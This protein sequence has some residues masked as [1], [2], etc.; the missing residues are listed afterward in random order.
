MLNTDVEK[1]PQQD[2]HMVLNAMLLSPS[3]REST[4]LLLVLLLF[5]TL[6]SKFYPRPKEGKHLNNKLCSWSS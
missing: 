2:F 5:S 1:R 3:L 6:D 4:A